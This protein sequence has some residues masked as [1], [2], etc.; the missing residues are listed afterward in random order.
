MIS[1]RH[2]E[3]FRELIESGRS[4]VLTTHM[5]PDGDALG[6]QIALARHLSSLGVDVR[7]VNSDPTPE[8]LRFLEA[9]ASEIE[10][11]DSSRHADLLASAD[12][13]VLLDNSA[14]DRLGVM[15]P[16]MRAAAGR[17]LCI[18]HHPTRETPWAHEILDES[19][20]ATACIVYDLIIE[21]DTRL[22][23]DTAQALFVGLATDTGFFRF[24]ST[25][26]RAFEIAAVLMRIGVNPA[27]CYQEIYERNS[28]RFT[29]LLG[30]GLAGM[31][32]DADGEVASIRVTQAMVDR[33][34]AEGEDTS[35]MT[36][37]LLA[38]DRVRVA[39]LFREVVPDQV[40]VSLR[41][42][43]DLDVRAL[44]MEFGGGGHRNASGI[45]TSGALDE[46]ADVVIAKAA[47][48]VRR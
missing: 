34:G 44:A 8:N 5:N 28:P 25:T 7:I 31:H 39:I 33:C 23:A 13:V 45:V 38:M 35:E 10:E 36:T 16:A 41:S 42:K 9:G 14:P 2:H 1:S 3:L 6:S 15:E 47:E 22:D 12:L 26:P 29:R 40:K 32:L 18:D 24:N 43:G 20:C 30:E 48:L 21:A 17:V 19:E 46:V 11:F 4:F 37:A 27:F